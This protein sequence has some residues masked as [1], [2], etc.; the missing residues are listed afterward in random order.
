MKKISIIIPYYNNIDYIF[1]SIKSI[2]SQKYKNFEIILIYDDENKN[3]LVILK[4][5]LK[6]LK[7]IKIINNKKNLGAAR[8]RN[9]GMKK[10]KGYYIAFLD[11]D[12]YWKKDKLKKQIEFMKLNNLDMSFTAYDILKN[13]QI[14]TKN[15]QKTYTYKE[16]LKK[17]DIGLSTVIIKSTIINKGMFP[18]LKTQEDYCLWLNYLRKKIVMQGLNKSLAVWRDT[19]NSLSSNIIQKLLDAFRVYYKYQN[20]NFFV[21]LFGV[22]VLSVNKIK[23]IFI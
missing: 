22:L 11:S 13:G 9:L 1:T 23:K 18:N 21:S 10:A 2:Y 19:P 17:C 16:L 4:K 20:K 15:V 6:F 14:K 12:D 5:K 8:C 7:N 3:D